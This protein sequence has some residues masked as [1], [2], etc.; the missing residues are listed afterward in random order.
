MSRMFIWVD[1]WEEIDRAERMERA[2]R[3]REDE[4]R[5]RMEGMALAFADSSH[6][7]QAR[8]QAAWDPIVRAK[9]LQPPAPIIFNGPAPEWMKAK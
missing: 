1:P 9:A 4:H 6:R 8:M 5:S 2:W 3:D 7:L